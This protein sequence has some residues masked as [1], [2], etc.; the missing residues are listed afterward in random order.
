MGLQVSYRLLGKGEGGRGLT[1]DFTL[2]QVLGDVLEDTGLG[3]E[4]ELVVK[5]LPTSSQ[6]LEDVTWLSELKT[7]IAV[8]NLNII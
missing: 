7:L 6:Q 1:E 8:C 4:E 5:M 2:G 3:V